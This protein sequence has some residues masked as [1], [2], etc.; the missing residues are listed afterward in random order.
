MLIL[1]AFVG[2]LLIID[3]TCVDLFNIRLI[4]STKKFSNTEK[5]KRLKEIRRQLGWGQAEMAKALKMDRSYLSQLEGGR[6]TID[7][8]YLDRAET[9][10]REQ[11]GANP[12]EVSAQ[13]CRAYLNQFLATCGNDPAR[14]GWTLVELKER[15]PLDRWKKSSL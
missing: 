14:L 6:R 12:T 4:M 3:V 11:P 10:A 1:L 7:E 5:G 9:I 15:F 13:A 2:E 8:Y